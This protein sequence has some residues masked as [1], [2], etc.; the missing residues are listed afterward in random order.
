[1]SETWTERAACAGADLDL[2]F[3]EVGGG[4]E[5]GGALRK[6]CAVCPVQVNCRE[7]ADRTS[8]QTGLWGGMSARGRRYLRL[9]GKLPQPAPG[10]R[11]EWDERLQAWQLALDVPG[12]HARQEG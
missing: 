2:F 3:P 9:Y 11:W 12:G 5:A 1:M 6:Y 7:Y 4:G 10:C 8:A